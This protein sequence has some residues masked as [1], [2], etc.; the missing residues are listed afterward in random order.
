MDIPS[1]KKR[2]LEKGDMMKIEDLLTDGAFH[3]YFVE[4][5]KLGYLG[6]LAFSKV[7]QNYLDSD[8]TIF[9]NYMVDSG[10]K[11]FD[12]ILDELRTRK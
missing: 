10:R 2:L 9:S 11:E 8:Y 3:L 6:R 12:K 4:Y 5:W 1:S 7:I